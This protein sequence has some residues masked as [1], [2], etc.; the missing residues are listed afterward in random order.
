MSF[1]TLGGP[2][3]EDCNGGNGTRP[4][5]P[6]CVQDLLIHLDPY[7]SMGLDGIHTRV[8]RDLSDIIMGPLTIIFHWSWESVEVPV[9]WKLANVPIFRKGKTEDPGIYRPVSLT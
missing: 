6:E 9:A 3:L 1:G 8:L 2:E 4:D 7:K 5:N